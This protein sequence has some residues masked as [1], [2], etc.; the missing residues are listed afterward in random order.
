MDKKIFVNQAHHE[1]LVTLVNE[2]IR[3]QV[4][5]RIA[6]HVWIIIRNQIWNKIAMG[7]YYSIFDQINENI[8]Q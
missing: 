6:N 4:E 5:R 8:K 7:I 1:I 3:N 2:K